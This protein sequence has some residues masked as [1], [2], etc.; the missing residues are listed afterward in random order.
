M[1]DDC[2][3]RMGR[4]VGASLLCRV[5][6]SVVRGTDFFSVDWLL[7]RVPS[8]QHR[9]EDVSTTLVKVNLSQVGDLVLCLPL[10]VIAPPECS[11]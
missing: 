10:V 5:K 1:L 3:A 8:F 9:I 6:F 2:S 4:E 11:S 7:T